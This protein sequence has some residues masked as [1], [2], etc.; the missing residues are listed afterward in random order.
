[1]KQRVD[2]KRWFLI[3]PLCMLV[4]TILGC[5]TIANQNNLLGKWQNPNLYHMVLVFSS[6]GTIIAEQGKQ[7]ETATYKVLAD[8]YLQVTP[9]NTFLG[10][11]KTVTVKYHIDGDTL[12]LYWGYQSNKVEYKKVL[13]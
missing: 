5:N 10:I 8:E 3:I 7:I 4:L 1:M 2:S 9:I 6:D 13:Q 12:S 11:T